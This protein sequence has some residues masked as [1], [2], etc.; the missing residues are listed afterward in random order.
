MS[1]AIKE[2]SLLPLGTRTLPTLCSIRLME[3][4]HGTIPCSPLLLSL[5][6]SSLLLPLL[7]SWSSMQLTS[8]F[9][10]LLFCRNE[11]KFGLTLRALLLTTIPDSTSQKF[12]LLGSVP[13][14]EA[15]TA[16]RH[17]VVFLDFAAM[18][19]RQCQ[20]KDF[21]KWYARPEGAECLMGHKVR[22][23]RLV[24]IL[25][26]RKWGGGGVQKLTDFVC[27]LTSCA[28]S[29]IFSFLLFRVNFSQ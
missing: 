28:P 22:L 10:G 9:N 8:P 17:A 2:A 11:Y 5:C 7:I 27:P 24:E 14:R 29:P 12:L 21:E 20:E 26:G 19:E 1:L 13:R 25:L 16:D 15:G 3:E 4:R 23:E 18:R 6:I